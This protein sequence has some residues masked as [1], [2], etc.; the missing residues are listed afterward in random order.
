MKFAIITDQHFCIRESS[1]YFRDNYTE[2]YT[3]TFFPYLLEN[4]IKLIIC[5]GDTFEDRKK[6]NLLGLA[7]AREVYFDLA[8]K[9]GIQIISILGNHDVFYRNTNEINAMDIIAKGY[10]NVRIVHDTEVLDLDGF[11]LGLISWINKDNYESRMEFIRT[12]DVDM[13]GGHFEING[14]EMVKGS[15]CEGGMKQEDFK[16]FKQVVSGHFHIAS[17]IGNIEYLGNPSQT[18]KGDIGYIRGFRVFDTNTRD[19]ILVENP[20][21]VYDSLKYQ[22]EFDI[23]TFDFTPYKNRIITLFITS[24]HK[25]DNTKL[26]MFVDEMN[27]HTHTLDIVE[28]E[29]LVSDVNEEANKVEYSSHMEMITSWIDRE[30]DGEDNNILK[31]MMGEL[32]NEALQMTDDE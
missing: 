2:F 28:T 14:F 29:S 4:C 3:K 17:K 26:N 27:K 18:N 10:K 1:Q 23:N 21:N 32:Y 20:Y 16:R 13:L 7:H 24:W 31:D 25:V 22:D 6:M 9:H 12:C 11:K 30:F 19:M 15:F 8:E 5:L